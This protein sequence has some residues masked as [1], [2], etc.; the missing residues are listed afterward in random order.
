MFY[1]HLFT[2]KRGT[3][4]RIWL[5]AHWEKKVTKAQVFDLNLETTVQ[6][7]IGPQVKI[8][9]RSSGHLLLGVVK[10][11]SR[12]TKYLLADCNEAV[13]KIKFAFRPEQTDL[14]QDGMEAMVKAITLQEDFTDFDPHLT[15][16]RLL[17]TAHIL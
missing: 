5:A 7:I 9:L 13:V 17:I 14:P 6:D 2:S 3:L 11:Y 12:K 10:I 4:A 1:T 15:E 8:G 16:P